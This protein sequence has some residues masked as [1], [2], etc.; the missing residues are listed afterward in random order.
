MTRRAVKR[1][2]VRGAR[3]ARRLLRRS[4]PDGRSAAPRARPPLRQPPADRPRGL[5]GTLE[6]GRA[7]DDAVLEEVRRFLAGGKAGRAQAIAESLLRQEHTRELGRVAAGVV[8]HR[9]GYVELAWAQLRGLPPAT[10][11]RLAPAEYVRA[12]LALVPDETLRGVEALVEDDPPG[13]PAESWYEILAAVFG[14]GA[15]DVARDVFAVFDR[16]VKRDVPGWSDG[17]VHRDWLRPWVAADADSPSAP[18]PPDGRPVLAVMD[19]GHPGASRASANIGDHIQSIAGLAHVV[20]HQNVRLHGDEK[21]V[22]LLSTLR[23][24]TR[25]EFR[26]DDLDAD[27]EVMPVHRDASTYQA[28]PEG[29]WVLCLGW[30]MHALFT[31]RHDFPLH[32]NL[33]PIFVSFHC[34]KRDLLTPAAVEYLRRYGPVGCRD[35]TTVHLLTSMNVP[36]FFSGCVTTTIDA[37]FPD[38]PAPPADA[39]VA[40]VD[41][42]DG[43]PE[44]A[45]TYAHSSLKV[46]RRSFVANARI[47]LD[48]LDTYRR[49]HS[50]VVTSR[51]HCHLPL[52][53]IGVDTEF[54]PAN[55]ADVRFA[56][57]AG[58]DDDAFGAIRSGLTEQLE[59]VLRGILAGNSEEDVY[60]AWRAAT[61]EP[62]AAALREH[63]RPVDLGSP[64]AKWRKRVPRASGARVTYARQ[65]APGAGPEVHCAVVLRKPDTREVAALL[66]SLVEHASRPIHL[67]VVSPEDRMRRIARAFPDVTISSIP[68]ASLGRRGRDLALVLLPGLIAD[69]VERL[70][71]LP[72]PAIATADVCELADVELGSHAL[73]APTRHGSG[74]GVIHTAAN[75][76]RN[77]PAAAAELRRAALARHEFDFD[78]FR[79]APLVLDLARLRR[80]RFTEEGLAWAK[81]FRLTD[82]QILHLLIGPDRAPVP[83]RWAVVPTRTPERGPGL[84]HWADGPKPWHELLT[85]ERELWRRHAV[86]L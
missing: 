56:G 53:S 54:V 38:A 74:F 29:T 7:L 41:V 9:R 57:L 12:G 22:D 69:D 73:A 82:V 31:M 3:V 13:V 2:G 27:L 61:A 75:R 63:R 64:A 36:A 68:I 78:P 58:I 52:R 33:R 32:R 26:R 21:L 83:E 72:T 4:R 85:P 10:W 1:L 81:T 5:I 50:R 65:T 42:H 8:A 40:Y 60:A 6:R 46:R 84:T 25:P 17:P 44:G 59:R 37:V 39:P 67:W 16:H 48:R 51:L 24:R 34:N 35:W 11:A 49:E 86:T 18:A 47:A 23:G 20:R 15:Q 30:Y 14:H 62:V 70:V 45:V 43:V 19:Y 28:I 80:E 71:V 66:D 77:R 79:P 76:L 55:P